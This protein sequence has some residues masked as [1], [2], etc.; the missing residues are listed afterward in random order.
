MAE[1]ENKTTYEISEISAS[2]WNCSRVQDAYTLR[3][4]PQVHGVV[5]DTVKFCQDIMENELNAATDNPMVFTSRQGSQVP[6]SGHI[7]LEGHQ[8]E[9]HFDHEILTTGDENDEQIVSGGNFHGEYPA[10]AMDYLAIGV[11]E[12]ANIS[13][14]RIARLI[15]GN[16]SGL[17]AFLVKEGGINSGFMIAHCTASAL[18]SE[19][20]VLVHPSSNDTLSTS[21]AK[22]DHV[23]MGPF[24]SMKC[25]DVVKNV[26]YVLAIELM[27]ACQGLDLLR[28][29]K[30]TPVLE[31]VYSLVRSVVPPYDKDRFLSP[32]IEN[33]YQLI[34]TGK[35]WEAV[36]DEIPGELH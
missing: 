27:C 11:T 12:L 26:E 10:K 5:N 32:D 28:P 29:L 9:T 35:I 36:K 34:K 13:E 14:R 33:I 1:I 18:T 17:P 20:K 2:H 23:S 30:T 22:E 19:N 31:K 16:L 25:L 3:C 15:D 4:M 6:N 7:H 8:N 21:A 24:A